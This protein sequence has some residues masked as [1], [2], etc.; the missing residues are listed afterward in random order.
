MESYASMLALP[1]SRVVLDWSQTRWFPEAEKGNRVVICMRSHAY[2]GLEAGK[3]YR[4]TLFSPET[5]M[6]GFL[7]KNHSE[8]ITIVRER[9]GTLR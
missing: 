5:N 6:G 2:W 3:K 7:R 8:I 9:L 4:G 1:S